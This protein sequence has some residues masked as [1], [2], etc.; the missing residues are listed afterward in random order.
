MKRVN[1]VGVDINEAAL[2]PLTHGPTLQFVCGLGPRKAQHLFR[3]IKSSGVIASRNQL[4]MTCKLGP[5]ASVI[6]NQTNSSS[7]SCVS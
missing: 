1:E 6:H 5:K 3:I 7:L 4:V 2:H